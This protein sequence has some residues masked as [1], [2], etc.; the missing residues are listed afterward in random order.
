MPIA[1]S[2]FR[3]YVESINGA[4]ECFVHI[5]QKNDIIPKL[6]GAVNGAIVEKI[7]WEVVKKIINL[8][9]KTIQT[10]SDD[11]YNNCKSIMDKVIDGRTYELSVVNRFNIFGSYYILDT[12][13][14]SKYTILPAS[15]AE[16]F[17]RIC[18]TASASELHRQYLINV[19]R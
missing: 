6:F 5:V 8:P 15:N 11:I 19:S 13:L 9:L 12:S 10:Q 4:N 7:L 17:F 1:G 18:D 2:N 3:E 14:D 16:N